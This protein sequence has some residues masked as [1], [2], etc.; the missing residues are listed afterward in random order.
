DK[1]KLQSRIKELENIS[2]ELEIALI[3]YNNSIKNFEKVYENNQNA[4]IMLAENLNNI[5][6]TKA[7]LSSLKKLPDSF[8]NT[9][10]FFAYHREINQKYSKIQDDEYNTK[11]EYN[12]IQSELPDTT[13]EEMEGELRDA[14]KRHLRFLN[15]LKTLNEIKRAFNETKLE[16]ASDPMKELRE[17]TDKYLKSITS[18]NISIGNMDENMN[19]KIRGR[20]NNRINYSQLSEGSRDSISLALRLSFIENLFKDGGCFT[21]FDDVLNDLDIYRKKEAIEIL[22]QFS[23]KNQVIFSTCDLDLA[24]KLGGNFIEVR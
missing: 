17:G 23:K 14:E 24:K 22:K 18:G 7:A 21:F 12:R 13:Y 6:T 2:R 8:S 4:L 11:I 19:L 5:K 16:M 20:F 3:S 10:E 1:D 9:E 15:Q